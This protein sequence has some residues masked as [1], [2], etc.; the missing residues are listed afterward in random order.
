MD[1]W[2][3][4]FDAVQDNDPNFVNEL[5]VGSSPDSELSRNGLLKIKPG[6]TVS[7]AFAYEL[8][9]E[10]TPVELIAKLHGDKV[11]SQTYAVE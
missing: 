5:E 11:G 10:T 2:I 8:D 7:Y 4:T 9:D 1:P 3:S 6:G